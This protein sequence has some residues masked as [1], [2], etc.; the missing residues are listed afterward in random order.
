VQSQATYSFK[1]FC[2]VLGLVLLH[3]RAARCGSSDENVIESFPIDADGDVLTVPVA[4][5]GKN[6]TFMIDT[7]SSTTVF[8]TSLKALLRS[9]R[10]HA[11]LNGRSHVLVYEC[12]GITI[13]ASKIPVGKTGICAGL[14]GMRDRSSTDIHGIIGMNTL[15]RCVLHLDFDS[16]RGAF[17]KSSEGVPGEPIPLGAFECPT[18]DVKIP[19][20][21][22]VAFLVDTGFA[23]KVNG[24]L[25]AAT[26]N[27]LV[28]RT[29]FN[30]FRRDRTSVDID[31]ERKVRAG[32]L[33]E[34]S[35]GD[36]HHFDAFFMEGKENQLGLGYLCRFT[37]TF[38]FPKR[39]MFLE[40]ASQYA[41]F[42]AHEDIGAW[43]SLREGT[44]LVLDVSDN[45]LAHSVGLRPGDH[46]I[47]VNECD[48]AEAA[49][50]DLRRLLCRAPVALSLRVVDATGGN[51]REVRLAQ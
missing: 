32:T 8:D 7:G 10:T 31:G 33:A 30:V 22:Q 2:L 27:A 41:R 16:G 47:R 25:A 23:G 39:K 45:G 42:L 15:R 5:A 28:K 43:L 34:M 1:I 12:D 17:L 9:T 48:T 19:E 29:Q 6:Y 51:P 35:V 11:P 49:E 18:I 3:A 13:G 40:K 24:G 21:G 4:I 46:V 36:F 50:F 37:V 14:S 26:L 38:D 20:A 44:L